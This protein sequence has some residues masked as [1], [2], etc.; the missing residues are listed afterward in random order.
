MKRLPRVGLLHYTCPPIIGGVETILYEQASRLSALGYPVTILSGR[1]GPLPAPTNVQLVIVPELDSKHPEVSATRDALDRGEIPASFTTL[2]AC[3]HDRLA[4]QLAALDT[5][6]VH[7]ALTLHFNLPLTSALWD[8]ARGEGCRVISWCHDLSWANPLYQPR[9]H[10]GE[11]WSLLRRPNP[12]IAPVFISTQRRK[13]WE[14][15]TGTTVDPAT[16]IHNGIDPFALLQLGART[17]A[18]VQQFGLAEAD[19]V[20]LA[21]VR[22]TKRKNLEWAIEAA[23]AIQASGKRVRLLITGPPGPHNPRAL[24]YVEEL[25]ALRSHHGLEESVCFLFEQRPAGAENEYA[26]DAVTL[27]DLYMLSDVVTLPSTSEG[28]GLPLA[29]AAIFR[30]PVV[31][32]DLPAFR[33]V[34]AT[35]PHFVPIEAGSSGF[36]RA[37]MAALDEPAARLRRQI[38]RALSWDIII[39]QQLE[40]LLNRA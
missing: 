15:L 16:V 32:T 30:T 39:R 3:L 23:A 13:E 37:V 4:P 18:L 6:I 22:I 38:M 35:A 11:P 40:P 26:V 33:E 5:L 24:R 14:H 29:E 28:F 36:T 10:P 17:R 7:N 2:R 34:A 1:G 19:V 20:M 12:Q 31:C 21:P 8:L 27:A 9:M 25:K